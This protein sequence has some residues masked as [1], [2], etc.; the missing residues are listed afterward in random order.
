MSREITRGKRLRSEP[1][2][3]SM[4]DASHAVQ[5]RYL[6][7]GD[8]R[9]A[10][11]D[12]D[13]VDVVTAVLRLHSHGDVVLPPEAH[14]SWTPPD[15]GGA[16]SLNMPSFVG[17]RFRAAGTKIINANP[18]NVLS[19]SPRASGLTLLFDL[20]GAQVS[21]VMDAGLVSAT[22]TAAVTIVAATAASAA[23]ADSLALLGAGAI[24]DAHLDLLPRHLPALD[25]VVVHDVAPGRAEAFAE[26]WRSLLAHRGVKLRVAANAED[27]VRSAMLV[28]AVTTT[29]TGY[30]PYRWFRPGAVVVHVSLDDLLPE[31][32]MLA[33]TVIVDDWPL[34]RDDEHRLF[35]R[36]Y[37]AGRLAGPGEPAPAGGR[38]VDA[39]LGDVLTGARPARR[40][41]D[42]I[43]VVNPFG[44]S[45][46]DIALASE[47]RVRAEALGL[48]I[49]L[50]R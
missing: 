23:P 15:G 50:P 14:L 12:V 2:E 16:R 34:V 26:R 45:I 33:D 18:Q 11:A 29:T 43:V 5:L 32:V 39:E 40:K 17:G 48:G 38:S 35:G 6:S 3:L 4:S 28:V 1:E 30:I 37:R 22:R 7:R 36:M 47:V 49:V 21:S 44:M 42:G 19:G 24:A 27:A 25:R 9:R 46:E 10:L 8:V 31:V 41:P 13:V 20:S